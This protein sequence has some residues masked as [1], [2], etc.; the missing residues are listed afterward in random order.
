MTTSEPSLAVEIAQRAAEK[1]V[2]S[3]DAP[4]SGGDVGAREARLSIMIGGDKNVVDALMPCWQAMGKTIVHQGGPGA[5]QHT[6]MV[7]QVLVA[8]S[9][10][11]VCEALLYGYRAGLDLN[12]VLESVGSGAAGSWSLSNLG[13]RIIAGNF[14]PGFLVEHFIK[15]MGIALAEAKRMKIMLPGLALVHQ[16]YIALAAQGH[17][18]D[19]TQSLELALASMSGVDW[20][21]R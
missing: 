3:I 5:G 4:V 20:G 21:Q 15:D 1:N 11:G 10:I 7:N 12:T 2:A 17:G 19:G 8:A 9:M 6:K 18:R 14:A 13:P 16:L